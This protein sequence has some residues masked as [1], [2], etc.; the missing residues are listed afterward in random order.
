MSYC[1]TLFLTM[2]NQNIRMLTLW[3]WHT[4]SF[5]VLISTLKLYMADADMV[6]LEAKREKKSEAVD[7][8]VH[9]YKLT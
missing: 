5:I 8:Q 2:I 7:C 1:F 3:L 6:H 4:C 9:Q